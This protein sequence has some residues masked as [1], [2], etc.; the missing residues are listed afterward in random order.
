MSLLIAIGE[1][2][3]LTFSST[4]VRGIT[5]NSYNFQGTST[6]G[7]DPNIYTIDWSKVYINITLRQNGVSKTI[8]ATAVKPLAQH[9][10]YFNGTWDSCANAQNAATLS[11]D[12]NGNRIQGCPLD[13]GCVINLRGDDSLVV[14]V[15]LQSDCISNNVSGTSYVE[16]D[17]IEGVGLQYSTPRFSTFA[18][19]GGESKFSHSIGDN[20]CLVSL[21]NIASQPSE[22]AD[23]SPWQNARLFSDRYNVNDDIGQLATKRVSMFPTE[24]YRNQSFVLSAETTDSTQVQLDLFPTNN[25]TNENYLC[26][27][28]YDTDAK[29]VA[30]AERRAKKHAKKSIEKVIKG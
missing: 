20:A 17:V 5:L 25:R 21:Q 16:A 9:L 29:L 11:L 10:N 8:C 6:G 4:D 23:Q 26:Y 30:T 28:T 15:R 22:T 18:I 13:F 1:K 7:G 14:E 24:V 27:T 3:S 2:K 19:N 12:Q